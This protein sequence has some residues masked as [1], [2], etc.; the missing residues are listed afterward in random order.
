MLSI[1]VYIGAHNSCNNNHESGNDAY[2]F[3]RYPGTTEM[4]TRTFREQIGPRPMAICYVCICILEKWQSV[5]YSETIRTTPQPLVAIQPSSFPPVSSSQSFRRYSVL[6]VCLM[7]GRV[8]VNL[9][10]WDMPN[11]QNSMSTLHIVLYDR[12]IHLFD[13]ASSYWQP[14]IPTVHYEDKKH[15]TKR[16]QPF[17]PNIHIYINVYIFTYAG[18]W[19]L[20]MFVIY[21]SNRHV[22][23]SAMELLPPK[24]NIL[25]LDSSSEPNIYI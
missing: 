15:D 11:I 17:I 1:S 7:D 24:R 5:L 25:D 14:K 13:C 6:I 3:H 23:W 22:F 4:N 8:N 21:K 18:I 19:L 20:H 9:T 16:T 2:S 12:I 10:I